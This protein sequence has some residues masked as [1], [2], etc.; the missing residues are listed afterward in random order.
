MA[1]AQL[2]ATYRPTTDRRLLD[3]AFGKP[4]EQSTLSPWS[5]HLGASGVLGPDTFDFGFHTEEEDEPWW[6]VDLLSPFPISEIRVHNRRDGFRDNARTLIVEA[7][8]D[9]EAWTLIHAGLAYFGVEGDGGPLVCPLDGKTFFRHVRLRLRENRYFHLSRVEVLIDA[10]YRP[11]LDVREQLD[12]R[13]PFPAQP[14]AA[15]QDGYEIIAA[16]PEDLNKPLIGLTISTN[17]LF[18]NGVF[19]YAQALSV[20]R[21]LGLKYIQ[22]RQGFPFELSTPLQADGIVFLPTDDPL[23]AGGAFLRGVFFSRDPFA[24]L[25]NSQL[26]VGSKTRLNDLINNSLTSEETHQNIAGPIKKLIPSLN[27]TGKPSK[28][29]DEVRIHIRSGDIFS[30]WIHADYVQPPLAFYQAVIEHLVSQDKIKSV[31]LIFQD[32]R[33]PVIDALESW[34]ISRDLKAFCQSGTFVDDVNALLNARYVVYGVGTFGPA[35]CH[36]SNHVEA[37]YY[38]SPDSH[39]APFTV[40]PTVK[41]VFQGVDRDKQYI[42]IGDWANTPEQR[43]RMIDYPQ[44]SIE[45]R[46]HR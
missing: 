33:N 23:P 14:G 41:A 44:A 22:I 38:F 37:V 42:Q 39:Y 46:Q 9:G 20:A 10:R 35:I 45:L 19:Q 7:S 29:R 34:I 24:N 3:V 21:R 30:T 26:P 5:S 11:F 36:L 28:P 16:T 43:A 17:C 40:I 12:L 13:L 31:T 18:G 1:D 6:R 27:F 2:N 8:L 25:L 32:R 15:E 4:A